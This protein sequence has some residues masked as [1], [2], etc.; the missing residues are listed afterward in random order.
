MFMG[1]AYAAANAFMFEQL[2]LTGI[3]TR[4]MA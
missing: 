1:F 4:M 3:L 2:R